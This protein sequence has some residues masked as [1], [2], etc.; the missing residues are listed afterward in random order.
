M[1]RSSTE[2][3]R[4]SQACSKRGVASEQKVPGAFFS[5]E[6]VLVYPR[7]EAQRNLQPGSDPSPCGFDR[8]VKAENELL[9]LHQVDLYAT[10]SDVTV[11]M[12]DSGL[13]L[14]WRWVSDCLQVTIMRRK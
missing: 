1:Q 9:Y 7:C 2:L 11:T 10:K 4:I 12:W 13:P 5:Q 3:D 14:T 6:I 8:D